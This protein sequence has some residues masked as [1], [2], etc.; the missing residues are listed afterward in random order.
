MYVCVCIIQKPVHSIGVNRPKLGR[1]IPNLYATSRMIL[2]HS[3]LFSAFQLEFMSDIRTFACS[4]RIVPLFF[5]VFLLF[6]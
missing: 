5:H 3:R 6:V 2:I 4:I 1:T